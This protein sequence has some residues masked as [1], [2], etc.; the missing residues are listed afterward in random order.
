LRGGNDLSVAYL[1]FCILDLFRGRYKSGCIQTR[2][3]SGVILSPFV[4]LAIN[5]YRALLGIGLQIR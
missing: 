5:A 1:L 4:M 2:W 3:I